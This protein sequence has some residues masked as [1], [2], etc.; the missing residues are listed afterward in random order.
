M[1]YGSSQG[2]YPGPPPAYSP[3]GTSHEPTI[4]REWESGDDVPDDFKYGVHVSECSLNIRMAFVRK[5]YSILF[6]QIG[7]TTVVAAIFMHNDKV[8]YWVQENSWA[9]IVSM[10]AT[11]VILLLLMWKRRSYPTNFALLAAFTL[12]ESYSL[13]TLVTFFD[14]ILVLQAFIIT[15]GLFI[16]LTLFTMQSKYDF[17]GMFSFL[18][19]G[20]WVVVIAGI[21]SIF[22][23]FSTGFDLAIAVFTAILFSGF[24]I[25][26]TFNIMR[27]ISPEE[28]VI[29]AVELYLDF[30]NLF[31]AILRILNDL[32]RD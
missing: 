27:R 9:L 10:I 2:A 15:S 7:L 25:Y 14:T 23:P 28:Y 13:G 11:F 5:V 1:S 26:D 31:I 21:V 24:V 6:A 4:G 16:G 22:I 3:V 12:V 18:Y 20:L 17:S 32:N 29:A 30:I 19:I 8:K